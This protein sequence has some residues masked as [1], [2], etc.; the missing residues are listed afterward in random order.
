MKK[1]YQLKTNAVQGV[2]QIIDV[3]PAA[4]KTP[5]HLLASP[6]ARYELIDTRLKAAPDNIRVMR[7][8]KNLTVFFDDDTV[9][10]VV[11]E[12][13]YTVHTDQQPTLIGRTDQGA[14]YEYI[15]ESAT[16]SA[17]VGQLGDTGKLSGMAL[18]SQELTDPVATVAGLLPVVGVS[19]WLLGAGALGIAAAAGGGGG[20]SSSPAKGAGTT[21]P[22]SNSDVGL[23]LSITTDLNNDGWVN[24]TELN[25]KATFTSR[26][27]F[28][29]SAVANDKIVFT[30]SNN[31]GGLDP[32]T[33]TLTA[34]D[35]T[36]GYVDITFAIPTTGA[37]QKV[38]ANYVSAAGNA[39][40]TPM[41]SDSATLDT[42]AATITKSLTLNSADHV[43]A[44]TFTATENG[45]YIL[46]IGSQQF[47]SMPSAD[48]LQNVLQVAAK[49]VWLDYWD[50]AGN[51]SVRIYPYDSTSTTLFTVDANTHFSLTVL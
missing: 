15:P 13:F 3:T 32:I 5:V 41:P 44:L 22:P 37:L 2:Q 30:A 50:A 14:L 31:G 34:Q 24:T 21:T 40:M 46:N 7:E 1:T 23:V 20:G 17:L 12:S 33:H 27:T 42:V 48:R 39:A 26:A 35:I 28:N 16:S 36:N 10:G 49:D 25:G 19:P 47:N 6:N 18:G 38:T 45:H 4:G 9:P 11:I 29:S 8:G 43:D 51:P